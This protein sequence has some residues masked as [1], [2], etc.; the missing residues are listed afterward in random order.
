MELHIGGKANKFGILPVD[1]GSELETNVLE[2]KVRWQNVILC[3]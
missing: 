1:I 2:E 3:L